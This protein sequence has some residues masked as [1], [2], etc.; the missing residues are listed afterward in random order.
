MKKTVLLLLIALTTYAQK[1]KV[2]VGINLVPL[3]LNR[4]F[5]LPIEYRLDSTK[6]ITVNLGAT[7]NNSQDYA[8]CIQC[9]DRSKIESLNA[10]SIKTN[11]RKYYKNKRKSQ[12]F[13]GVGNTFSCFDKSYT[14]GV[15]SPDEEKVV[16]QKYS[17][18]AFIFSPNL[19]LGRS[20]FLSNN[21][22]LDFGTQLNFPVKYKGF[23]E[24]PHYTPT[25]GMS[26]INFFFVLKFKFV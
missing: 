5:D 20:V 19:Q 18:K 8:L 13:F 6:S 4:T 14:V 23:V 7:F 3:A 26:I 16:N 9:A 22:N 17:R 10:Y 12:K 15:Y 24:P 11:F 21:F 2:S 25:R 1:E